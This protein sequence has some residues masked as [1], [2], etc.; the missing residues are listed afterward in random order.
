[1]D[2]LPRMHFYSHLLREGEC[3]LSCEVPLCKSEKRH[4]TSRPHAKAQPDNKLNESAPIGP[5]YWA[6]SKFVLSGLY[7]LIHKVRKGPSLSRK[8]FL[9]SKT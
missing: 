9:T 2:P 8:Y 3:E 1:M 6:P 4:P 5:L 7:F